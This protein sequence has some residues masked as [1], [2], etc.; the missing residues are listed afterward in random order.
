MLNN[1][2]ELLNNVLR[3]DDY[4]KV[5]LFIHVLDALKKKAPFN[6]FEELAIKNSDY[7]TLKIMDSLGVPSENKLKAAGEMILS[8]IMEMTKMF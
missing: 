8:M 1:H 2:R 4:E 3:K 6:R 5:L 7:V